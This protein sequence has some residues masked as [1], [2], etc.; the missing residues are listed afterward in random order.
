ML[1]KYGFT[2]IELLVVIAK[3]GVLAAF[4]APAIGSARE[5][6]RRIQCANNLRQIGIA[7]MISSLILRR[8]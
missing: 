8:A 4:L 1:R 3:I 7:V 6:G 2:L 5:S